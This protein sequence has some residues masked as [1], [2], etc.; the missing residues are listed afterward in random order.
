MDVCVCM[1]VLF[2]NAHCT[3]GTYQPV[4]SLHIV[5]TILQ[6]LLIIHAMFFQN[7]KKKKIQQ[8]KYILIKV[9]NSIIKR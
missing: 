4:F 8:M 1:C 9:Y 3:R 7:L 6:V 2:N 5:N